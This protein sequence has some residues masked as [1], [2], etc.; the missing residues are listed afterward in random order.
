LCGDEL[1]VVAFFEFSYLFQVL[2]GAERELTLQL[3]NAKEKDK[4]EALVD[5]EVNT[6][7]PSHEISSKLSWRYCPSN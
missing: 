5:N 4:S 6:L 1:P 3:P 7:H 2:T